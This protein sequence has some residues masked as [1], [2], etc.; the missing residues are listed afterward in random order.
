MDWSK[1]KLQY[2][3]S[4]AIIVSYYRDGEWSAPSVSLESELSI[5]AFG[6]VFHYGCSCFEGLKAFRGVDDKIRI[7]RAKDNAARLA[8]SAARLDMAVPS[9]E[10]FMR[11]CAMCVQENIDFLPP[12]GYNASMY[13]RPVLEGINPQ[14]NICS[15]SEL[16]FAVM[17]LPMGSFTST[18]T[19]EPVSAVIS[20]N[21]DRAAVNGTG[22]FKI[23]ANYAASL[24]PYSIAHKQGYKELLFLDPA[25]K[26]Y[27]DEFGSSNFI[28]IKG[29]R[30]ITPLSDS[31][32]P[33]ITNASLQA[34]A[35]EL[36]LKV[37]KRKIEVGELNDFDEVA[38]C[39]TALV[40]TPISYIDDKASLEDSSYKK[41]YNICEDSSRLHN[42]SK[43]YNLYRAIQNGEE[44]DIFQWCTII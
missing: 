42:L 30:F 7:F 39:G 19:L 37:E 14:I 13:L 4:R 5:H 41:R 20:R 27:I 32:L 22:A 18:A 25:S 23:G 36:G 6:G 8:R 34:L 33:S 24:Y 21:Y 40:V 31:V 44:P 29:D 3:P 17:C 43:L 11:M 16:L 15:S 28:A 10:L 35:A 26:Q 12:Y 38:A 9:E 2:S 1:L